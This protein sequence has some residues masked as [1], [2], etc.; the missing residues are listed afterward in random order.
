MIVTAIVPCTRT[1]MV[2][3]FKK[4]FKKNAPG[5]NVHDDIIFEF[6]IIVCT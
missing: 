3:M 5:D 6:H 4:I 2:I 1:C